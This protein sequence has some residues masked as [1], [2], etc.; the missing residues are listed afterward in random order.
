[1]AAG[2]FGGW[3]PI[4]AEKTAS[5]YQIVWKMTG[6]DQFTEWNTDNSGNYLSNAIGV[7]SGSSATLKALETTFQQDFNGN[8]GIGSALVANGSAS[9]AS[10]SSSSGAVNLALLTNYLASTYAPPAGEGL[11][12]A[13]PTETSDQHLLAHPTA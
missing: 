4:G 3:T 10:V 6:A 5:G 11:S 8:G 12:S 7:V 9:G 13:G 1:V 2:Q